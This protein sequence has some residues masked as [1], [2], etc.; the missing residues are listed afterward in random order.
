MFDFILA[1]VAAFIGPLAAGPAPFGL[2]PRLRLLHRPGR[3]AVQ[4]LCLVRQSGRGAQGTGPAPALAQAG[5][6][7]PVHQFPRQVLH[8]GHAAGPGIPPQPARQFR[9]GRAHGHRHLVRDVHQRPRGLPVQERRPARVAGGQREQLHRPLPEQPQIGR[10]A[11]EPPRHE[12]ERPHR[13]LP[14]VARM[15]LP[16]RVGLYSEGPFP[17][18]QDDQADRGKGGQPPAA[19]DLRHQAGRAPTR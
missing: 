12:P 2:L 8:A 5:L 10:H 9:G 13:G 15:G 19:G 6:E 17:R 7:G 14:E 1:A 4:G 11:R 3:A 16:V 18:C